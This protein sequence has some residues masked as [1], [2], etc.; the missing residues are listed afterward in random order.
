LATC[1]TNPI[2]QFQLNKVH[3]ITTN[4]D[5]KKVVNVDP[6]SVKKLSKSQK[7]LWSN[8]SG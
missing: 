6:K 4:Y 7:Y 8:N 3:V 5:T 1:D 2:F